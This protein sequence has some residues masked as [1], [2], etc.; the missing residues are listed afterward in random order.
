[1]NHETITVLCGREN[2]RDDRGV[3]L[4]HRFQLSESVCAHT[5]VDTWEQAVADLRADH[6]GHTLTYAGTQGPDLDTDHWVNH[7]FLLDFTPE[8][9]IPSDYV[10]PESV[11]EERREA[12]DAFDPS[13]I[14]RPVPAPFD[15][16]FAYGNRPGPRMWPENDPGPEVTNLDP[17][18]SDF[19]VPA[20][21]KQLVGKAEAAG[22]EVRLGYSLGPR[23]AVKIGTYDRVETLGVWAGP[24]PDS[25]WRFSA[26]YERKPDGAPSA[27]KWKWGK[28]S[29]W[30]ADRFPFPYCNVTEL[31]EWISVRA[32]VLPSWFEQVT[33]RVRDAEAKQKAPKEEANV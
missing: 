20:A 26:M 29:I 6:P 23:R 17:F 2:L 28:T 11:K 33:K 7:A 13:T 1:M 14:V 16:A 24:H 25:G 32:S 30:R 3:L 21:V 22:W 19:T 8:V 27:Q 5:G 15:P 18:P 9:S 4:P 31:K 10:E 12:L